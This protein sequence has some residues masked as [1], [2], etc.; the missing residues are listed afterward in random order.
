MNKQEFLDLKVSDIINVC[1][2]VACKD[3]SFPCETCPF[4]IS[5]G[6]IFTC[7]PYNWLHLFKWR[8]EKKNGSD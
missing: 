3:E 1:E 7:G 2:K 4:Y 8:M 6:C 5:P